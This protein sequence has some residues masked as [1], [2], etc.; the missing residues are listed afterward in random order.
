MLLTNYVLFQADLAAKGIEYA[1][2]HTVALGLNA[3]EFLAGYPATLPTFCDLREAERTAAVLKRYGLQ[4]ACFSVGASLY[5]GDAKGAREAFC[6]Y[7]EIAAILGSPYLHH[8]I[9][10]PLVLPPNAPSYETV[11]GE[12]ID[13]ITRIAER[14]AGFGITCLYEPQG[15]YFNGVA[16]LG[17]LLAEMKKRAANVGVCGDVGNPLYVDADPAEIFTRFAADIR[18]VHVKDYFI[19]DEKP[20]EPDYAPTRG[21]RYVKLCDLGEG[22]VDLFACLCALR[23]VNYDGA[24]ALEFSGD[25]CRM[26]RAIDTFKALHA[27]AFEN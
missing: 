14:A 19:R 3:V 13:A 4:T 21:G 15:M 22:D 23:T 10:L 18:H 25:D 27:S 1:A 24:Y 2:E 5:G 20:E 7:A 17:T 26:R 12:T 9:C 8:T 6:R 16:G 11:L